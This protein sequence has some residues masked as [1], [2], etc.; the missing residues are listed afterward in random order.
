MCLL[1]TFRL[2]LT[3]FSHADASGFYEMNLDPEVIQY[4]GDLPFE[5]VNAAEKF[6]AVYN[7][8]EKWGYGRW[9]VRRLEDQEYLGFCGLKF[10]AHTGETDLGFR[11]ARAHWGKGYA[12]EAA[13]A[14]IAYAFGELGLTHLIGQVRT[15]NTASIHVLEKLGF[16]FEREYMQEG[17][18]WQKWA[19]KAL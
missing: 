13:E 7:A 10:H 8:Y 12:T 14:C 3:P 18:V 5:S 4:T 16:S 1:Q 17:E 15:E 19:L 9:T 11:F 6:I 2:C